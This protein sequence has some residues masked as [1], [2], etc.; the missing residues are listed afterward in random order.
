MSLE[1]EEGE[2]L[3]CTLLVVYV[4]EEE[5]VSETQIKS[6]SPGIKQNSS[7]SYGLPRNMP[8]EGEKVLV[9][10]DLVVLESGTEMEKGDVEGEG[11]LILFK[12]VGSVGE[13]P[14]GEDPSPISIMHPLPTDWVVKKVEELQSCVGIS[15][16]GYADQFRAQLIAIEVG[17][18]QQGAGPKRSREL[19]RLNW[20]INYDGKEGSASRGRN[21]GRAGIVDK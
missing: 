17:H 3:F 18:Y 4:G 7:M 12:P 1:E 10:E 2:I 6:V 20:S 21:K 19:K 8:M 9:A 11:L 5:L 15:C 14:E 16:E 13:E